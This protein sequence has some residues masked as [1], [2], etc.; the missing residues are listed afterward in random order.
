MGEEKAGG[1]HGGNARYYDPELGL[2][3]QPD[4]WKVTESDVGTNRYASSANDPLNLS[5]PS[6]NLPEFGYFEYNHINGTYA[7][8]QLAL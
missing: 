2:F 7:H 8:Q 1:G 4:W 3:L 6:G 5:D